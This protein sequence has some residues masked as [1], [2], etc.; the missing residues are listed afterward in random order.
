MDIKD[1]I[2]QN[3]FDDELDVRLDNCQIE[4]PADSNTVRPNFDPEP[5]QG[6]HFKP[7]QI[8]Q[9]N[10]VI[11]AL[12][13]TPLSLFQL[14]LPIETAADW[15]TFTN[16]GI[17]GPEGLMIYIGIHKEAKVADH[18]KTSQ[19]PGYRS[20]RPQ[21]T[22]QQPT[23]ES[24]RGLPIWF[25][26]KAREKVTIPTK[27]TPT[28]YKNWVVAQRGFFLRASYH[29][30]LDNL[31]SSPSLFQVLRQQGIGATGTCRTN[32]GLYQPFV[33]AKA[34]DSKGHRLWPH[35]KLVTVPTPDEMVNQ[36]AWK[37]NALV[38]LL[39]TVYS[40]REF[41]QRVRRRPN[42]T[43]PRARPIKEA[44]GKE[45]K[46]TMTQ[47]S[48]AIDYNDYMGAVDVGDQLRSYLGYDH[49]FRRAIFFSYVASQ[50]GSV[51]PV[52]LSGGSALST[53]SVKRTAD[54]GQAVRDF[55]P[56]TNLHLFHSIIT[57]AEENGHAV[58]LAKATRS[59]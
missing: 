20:T 51:I 7:L 29:V 1:I 39:S 33:T 21:K 19:Q 25:Q 30:F 35:N 31:F 53:R 5:S 23:S 2:I 14:F 36:I 4:Q 11:N 43:Q 22:A 27:P 55:E 45:N 32:C 52:K 41:Q 47:P 9:R 59:V 42:T 28:G 13:T 48:A 18:W 54:H 34:E 26:G 37:D 40:G 49:R 57:S 6:R 44:F 10:P 38:L 46:K 15:A 17:P 8:Q 12:P 58:Q 16:D 24:T 3:E 56:A 50:V